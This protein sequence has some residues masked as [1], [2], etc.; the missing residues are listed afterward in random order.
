MLILWFVETS[1]ILGSL[2]SQITAMFAGMYL[3]SL[4][5]SSRWRNVL[6]VHRKLSVRPSIIHKIEKTSFF[7]EHRHVRDSKWEWQLLKISFTTIN[8]QSKVQHLIRWKGS[9]EWFANVCR[10][11]PFPPRKRATLADVVNQFVLLLHVITVLWQ[12]IEDQHAANP[13]S[14]AN[15]MSGVPKAS[16]STLCWKYELLRRRQNGLPRLFQNPFRQCWH[17]V[18]NEM[19]TLSRHHHARKSQTTFSQRAPLTKQLRCMTRVST[20]HPKLFRFCSRALHWTALSSLIMSITI[21]RSSISTTRESS[22]CWRLWIVHDRKI[23]P[24][25][26][27]TEMWELHRM[28]VWETTT[29]MLIRESKVSK[30]AGSL[31]RWEHQYKAVVC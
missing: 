21:T 16:I 11:N 30:A 5:N 28:W 18:Q 6:A 9:T 15:N 13:F 23:R 27:T 2:S 10:R 7:V 14:A 24:P 22:V 17:E 20:W 3:L 25:F 26:K 31:W 8:V 19:T 4:S 12:W 29:A 1:G